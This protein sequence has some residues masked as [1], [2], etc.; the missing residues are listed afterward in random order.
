MKNTSIGNSS[1]KEQTGLMSFIHPCKKK[2]K[3]WVN[4][5]ELYFFFFVVHKIFSR[6]LPNVF[7]FSVKVIDKFFS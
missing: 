6:E 4:I 7:F 3:P 1:Q 2:K 5:C